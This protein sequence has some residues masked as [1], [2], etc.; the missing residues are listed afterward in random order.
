MQ[1]C[2]RLWACYWNQLNWIESL[3]CPDA[4]NQVCKRHNEI[5]GPFGIGGLQTLKTPP[6]YG[7][8][9]HHWRHSRR[10]WEMLDELPGICVTRSHVRLSTNGVIHCES[11]NLQAGAKSPHWRGRNVH[12]R[13]RNVQWVGKTSRV[14]KRPGAKRPGGETSWWRNVHR[15]KR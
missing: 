15:A 2:H 14:P 13:G 12:S 1:H 7:P 11:Y 10:H 5:C 4:W 3:S 9:L 8:V 6:S